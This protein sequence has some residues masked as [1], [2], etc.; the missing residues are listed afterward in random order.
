MHTPS[1]YLYI[2]GEGGEGCIHIYESTNSLTILY[3]VYSKA[4]LT[5]REGDIS[6]FAVHLIVTNQHVNHQYQSVQAGG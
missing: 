4:P 3:T 2:W 6:R 5:Y 1:K